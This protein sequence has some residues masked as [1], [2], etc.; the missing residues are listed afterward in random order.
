VNEESRGYYLEI[1]LVSLA[2]ILLEISY[3]RIFSFKLYYYFTYLIIGISLLGLGSGGVFVAIFPALRR[4][5]PSRLIVGCCLL[6]SAAIGAGYFVIAL[7]RVDALSMLE[8]PMEGAKLCFILLWLFAP[9]LNAGVIISTI[10][11]A[12]PS[13]INRLYCAD[14]LGAGLGCVSCI[15]LIYSL[16]PPGVVILSG[17]VFAAASLRLAGGRRTAQVVAAVLII[18]WLVPVVRPSVLPDPVPDSSKTLGSYDPKVSP[19]I[20]SQWS[21]VFRVDVMQHPLLGDQ[22]YLIN[23]DGQMGSGLHRFNGDWS[24]LKRFDSDP[25]LLPFRVLEPAPKVLIIGAAGGHE[26]LASLYFK[27]DHVTGV[28]LNPVTTSLL[29]KYFKDYSGRI[30]EN[31][32]VTLINAEGRS[33]LR[34]SG[35]DAKYDLVWFVAPDT[36]AAMNAATS[37]AFVLSESYLYTTQMITDSLSHLTED[38][39]ICA[40]FGEAFFDGKPNRTARYIAT[41]REAFA[42]LGITDFDKHVLVETSPSF[43]T[44]STI[45]LKKAPFT[46]EE[47]TRFKRAVGEVQGGVVRYAPDVPTS[48]A[49]LGDI[50]S[51]PADQLPAWF[52]HYPYDVSPVT[53]N[54]P[55]FWH[56]ARFRDSFFASSMRKAHWDLEDAV[57]ERVLIVL[58]AFVV[59]FATVFLLMPFLTIRHVWRA[60]P[61]KLNAVVYF[62]AL[63]MGF[64]FLEVCLIQMLTLFLGYPSY[65][66]SVTLFSL[67]VFTGVGSFATT[68][69]TGPRNGRLVTLLGGLAVL[70]VFYQFGLSHVI[71]LFV[72]SSLAVRFA[73]AVAV[74]APLG[75]LL[76]AFMPI[77]LDA[78][79]GVTEH[80]AEYI[81]WGWAVNGFFSVM[82]SILSTIIAMSYGFRVVLFIA[83]VVYVIGI[84]MMMRIPERQ[85]A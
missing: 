55:F 11:G 56:F 65:S 37:G 72:G 81:A 31:P 77:G 34:R 29:T 9:F 44:L 22:S 63:G 75:F 1:F 74:I 68:R 70:V 64:M 12:R 71:D 3:T 79:A 49:A 19:V 59:V 25:R 40:M 50:I 21:S 16:T 8:R 85:T 15:P 14:L 36:Y 35:P 38:G 58:L 26:V 67:L 54:A 4:V 41:A 13:E 46:A 53:D 42:R 82:S 80:K 76:G 48:P 32:K 24:T 45:L 66:L 2:V 78:I 57:G 60:I 20:F 18:A 52:E 62:G 73:V 39:I 61:Y 6:A 17:L 69:Y 10:F 51:L 23:H 27:A 7:L 33:F 47:I 28:E 83:L 43:L 30:A 5:A 84:A